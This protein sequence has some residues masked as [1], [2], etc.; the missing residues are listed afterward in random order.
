[1][2]F[3]EAEWESMFQLMETS[4]DESF[5]FQAFVLGVSA[6]QRSIN[7]NKIREVFQLID[8]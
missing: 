2:G 8:L 6:Y 5:N 1:M 4:A 3:N 7:Q